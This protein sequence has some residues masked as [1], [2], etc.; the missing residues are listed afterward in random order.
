MMQIVKEQW[1]KNKDKLEKALR[2]G[3]NFNSVDYKDLVKLVFD[4]VY[5]DGL[6]RGKVN[7]EK[8]TEIDDGYYDGTL[9]YMIPFDTY[10]PACYEYILTHVSYGSC[11]GCDTLQSIQGYYA[12]K[13]IDEQVKDFM[14]L[15]KDILTSA[16]RPYN[17]EHWAYE[18][19]YAK[20]VD[21]E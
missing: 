5:N 16:I 17:E 21:E 13:L 14:T 11:S 10:S 18:P 2:E 3:D 6:D 9:M 12:E 7:T 19:R 1:A 20:A 4:V 15:C 8:I